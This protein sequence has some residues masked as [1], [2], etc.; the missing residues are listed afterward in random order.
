MYN[1]F[2]G[3]PTVGA[4]FLAPLIRTGETNPA[5]EAAQP[6]W[7]VVQKKSP[8]QGRASSGGNRQEQE[9]PKLA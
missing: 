5:S 9:S 1:T 2:A 6:S 4:A 3:R 7:F 8:A